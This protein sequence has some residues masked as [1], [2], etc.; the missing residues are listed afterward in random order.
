MK[1]YS[2]L[3]MVL[4]CMSI[5]LSAITDLRVCDREPKFRITYEVINPK[6]VPDNF[7]CSTFDE[8]KNHHFQIPEALLKELSNEELVRYILCTTEYLLSAHFSVLNNDFSGFNG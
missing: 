8:L 7:S 4:F 6:F 2:V 1:R 5:S 3:Y